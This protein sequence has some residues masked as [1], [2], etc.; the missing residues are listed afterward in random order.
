MAAFFLPDELIEQAIEDF[1]DEASRSLAL[2]LAIPVRQ[3]TPE[4]RE[5]MAAL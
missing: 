4:E 2:Y 3:R 1:S 5:T